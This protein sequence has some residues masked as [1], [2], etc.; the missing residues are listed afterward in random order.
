LPDWKTVLFKQC[1]QAYYKGGEVKVV[2][3]RR[4]NKVIP[5]INSYI[6]NQVKCDEETIVNEE[7]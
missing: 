6:D 4:Q 2:F 7:D 5:I 1:E 3:I